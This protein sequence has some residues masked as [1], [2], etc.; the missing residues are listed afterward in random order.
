MTTR[1]GNAVGDLIST[2]TA[3]TLLGVSRQHVVNLCERGALPFQRVGSHRR[4]H[5]SAVEQLATRTSW[6]INDLQSWYLGIATAAVVVSDPG[7][8]RARAVV[9]LATMRD[10]LGRRSEH[11]IDEWT[12]RIDGPLDEM[13]DALVGTSPLAV[14][15]RQSSPFAGMLDDDT[16][17]AARAAARG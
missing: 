3:A 17:Q 7:A 15:L 2:G 11:W 10:A 9:N 12:R 14:A 1:T 5:R 4:V 16:R 6:P 13:I 8:A